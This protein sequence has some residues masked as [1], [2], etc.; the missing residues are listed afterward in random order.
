MARCDAADMRMTALIRAADAAAIRMP[1]VM[2]RR[3]RRS[4]DESR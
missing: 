1:A 2:G 3:D 4:G